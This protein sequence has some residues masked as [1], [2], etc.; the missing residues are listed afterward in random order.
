M[1]DLN[2][3]AERLAGRWRLI[4]I[5]LRGHGRSTLGNTPLTYARH[6]ADVR[7]VLDALGITRCAMF[8]FS[9]GGVVSGS[10]I[11]A[12]M[13]AALRRDDFIASAP[14]WQRTTTIGHRQRGSW[15][16][17][18]RIWSGWRLGWG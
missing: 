15:V 16:C 18:G 6:E 5:D 11:M 1:T 9:D 2:P 14:V 7:A 10:E 8:G 17:T 12:N 13:V 4:G 3:I